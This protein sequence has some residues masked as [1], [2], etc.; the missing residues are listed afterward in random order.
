MLRILIAAIIAASVTWFASTY[1]DLPAGA[2]GQAAFAFISVVAVL[3]IS[4]WLKY[5]WV[6]A[7]VIGVICFVATLAL[8]GLTM[9]FDHFPMTAFAFTIAA[10]S[11]SLV[12]RA[13]QALARTSRRAR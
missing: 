4:G 11:V 12:E 2:R 13:A 7:L 8:K 6:G 3:L 1:A 9:S 10:F 5:G